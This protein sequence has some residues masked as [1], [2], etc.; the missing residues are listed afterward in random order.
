M[1]VDAINTTVKI[2]VPVVWSSLFLK[3]KYNGPPV[4]TSNEND[5]AVQRRNN[6]PGPKPWEEKGNKRTQMIK[7][8]NSSHKKKRALAA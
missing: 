1:I 3:Y 8:Q 6:S 5:I 4:T 2:T 7:R